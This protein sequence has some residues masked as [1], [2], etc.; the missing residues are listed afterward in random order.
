[1]VCVLLKFC[2]WELFQ[3]DGGH[4]PGVTEWSEQGDRERQTD[5]DTERESRTGPLKQAVTVGVSGIWAS[6]AGVGLAV[7]A[8]M[9]Q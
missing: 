3:N 9:G 4:L 8:S 2:L 5:R 6:E 1:M 7:N